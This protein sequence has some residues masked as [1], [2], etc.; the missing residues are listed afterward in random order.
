MS[1]ATTLS[2]ISTVAIGRCDYMDAIVGDPRGVQLHSLFVKVGLDEREVLQ[3]LNSFQDHRHVYLTGRGVG[4]NNVEAT[5]SLPI[6]D[7]P[8]PKLFVQTLLNE[9]VPIMNT[10][11]VQTGKP[12]LEKP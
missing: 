9:D 10:E 3:I 6:L 2:A 4:H 7:K 1:M 11:P 8:N 12:I 5:S